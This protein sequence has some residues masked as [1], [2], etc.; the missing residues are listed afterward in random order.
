MIPFIETDEGE[1]FLATADARKTHLRIMEAIAY[2]ARN[3]NEANAIW[4]GK[5]EFLQ[6]CYFSDIWEYVTNNGLR[7]ASDYHWGLD[8]NSWWEE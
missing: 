3:T 4:E 5:G 1:A 6:L 8:G 7:D 2:F